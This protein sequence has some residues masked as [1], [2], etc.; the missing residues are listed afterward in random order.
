M[1]GR[2][3]LQTR[4]LYSTFS[5]LSLP[6]LALQVFSRLLLG[7]LRRATLIGFMGGAAIV[8]VTSS[9]AQRLEVSLT[10]HTTKMGFV[11]VMGSSVWRNIREH[12]GSPKLFLDISSNSLPFSDPSPHNHFIHFQSSK[13]HGIKTVQSYSNKL[14]SL[15]FKFIPFIL[16]TKFPENV[17]HLEKGL[18]PQPSA[19]IYNFYFSGKLLESGYQNRNYNWD[20]GSH[21]RNSITLLEHMFLICELW[22]KVHAKLLQEGIASVGRTFASLKKRTIRLM[23][24]K[25]DPFSPR[26]TVNYNAGAQATSL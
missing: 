12:Q 26:S 18:N 10:S 14:V 24:T 9:P 5:L 16:T 1:L 3:C 15:V 17:G 23:E 11:P 25:R 4:T 7:L 8:C 19:A 6:Q 20:F 22:L 13:K 2:W 21:C